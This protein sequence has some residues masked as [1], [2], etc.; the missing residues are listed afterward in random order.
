[1]NFNKLN[2]IILVIA[3]GLINLLGQGRNFFSKRSFSESNLKKEEKDEKRSKSV[4]PGE[5]ENN[6]QDIDFENLVEIVFVN[7]SELP[8]NL[9]F[10]FNCEKTEILLDKNLDGIISLNNFFCKCDC[11]ELIKIERE[12]CIDSGRNSPFDENDFNSLV[13]E[14]DCNKKDYKKIKKCGIQE[15][16]IKFNVNE[17]RLSFY[18]GKKKNYGHFE[19]NLYG[20]VDKMELNGKLNELYIIY[21]KIESFIAGKLTLENKLY[22]NSRGLTP[23]FSLFENQND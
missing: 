19:L 12:R 17:K 13:V 20:L 3:F 15:I 5:K 21:E 1:M 7:K 22:I 23:L 16:N 11:P 14:F 2:L 18:N 6:I 8:V 9:K 10:N 4:Y